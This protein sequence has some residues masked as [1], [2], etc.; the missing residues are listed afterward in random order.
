MI[1]PDELS[2]LDGIELV[3]ESVSLLSIMAGST[4]MGI[5]EFNIE[6]D[7]GNAR[8]L[9]WKWPTE[10]VLSP[11]ELG[12]VL[13]YPYSSITSDYNWTDRHPVRTA[14]EFKDLSWH[15]DSGPYYDMKSWDLT[16][17]MYAIEPDSGLFKRSPAGLVVVGEDGRTTFANTASRNARRL[18]MR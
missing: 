10:L 2:D 14:Y 7:I 18:S 9:F 16:S 3:R 6:R 11:F 15:K 17:V 12:N 5:V 13:H 1:Q 4:E 8:F